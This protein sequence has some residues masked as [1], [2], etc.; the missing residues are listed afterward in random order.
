MAANHQVA[1]Q[2]WRVFVQV[3][4]TDLYDH[5][6]AVHT[7][8]MGHWRSYEGNNDHVDTGPDE[9]TRV[10][11]Y[12]RNANWGPWLRGTNMWAT[13]ALTE[14]NR[15]VV[16]LDQL[17]ALGFLLFRGDKQGAMDETLYLALE[18][19]KEL[20]ACFIAGWQV[21]ISNMSLKD[22]CDFGCAAMF[23]A[24]WEQWYRTLAES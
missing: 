18:E 10:H 16:H 4:R 1:R 22:W 24:G 3:T 12:R 14:L 17:C 9:L 19:T 20:L 21:V 13:Q 2:A 23:E 5:M 6:D 7:T 11:W 8:A 15:R